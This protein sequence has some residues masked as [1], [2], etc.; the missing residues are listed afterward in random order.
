MAV[1]RA[2]PTTR[3]RTRDRQDAVVAVE[4]WTEP[5]VV[6]DDAAPPL[7]RDRPPRPDRG[8]PRREARD[9]PEEHRPKPAEVVVRDEPGPPPRARAALRRELRGQRPA[10]DRE[11][12]VAGH[13]DAADVDRVLLEHRFARQDRSPVQEHLGERRDAAEAQDDL[14]AGGGRRRP[15]RR[16]EPPVLGVQVAGL[17]PGVAQGPRRGP[18]HGRRDPCQVVEIVR[19]RA[20]ARRRGRR[21]PAVDDRDQDVARRPGLE[22][23][24]LRAACRQATASSSAPSASVQA[25]LR[26]V[27]ASVGSNGR[28][29]ASLK[30]R[31]LQPSTMRPIA[32]VAGAPRSPSSHSACDASSSKPGARH[33]ERREGERV[34]ASLVALEERRQVGRRAAPRTGRTGC[35]AGRDRDGLGAGRARPRAAPARGWPARRRTGSAPCTAAGRRAT[36]P[37]RSGTH[38]GSPHPRAR[39]ARRCG[40]SGRRS[41][42]RSIASAITPV[43][44]CPVR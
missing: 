22:R 15:E 6:D 20:L 35:P 26:A 1:G 44:T 24:S 13:E 41:R 28:R 23:T 18:G 40:S 9:A 39:R 42:S 10:A 27:M 33:P 12:V 7:Q 29:R 4:P 37:A 32:S 14:L 30:P 25:S 43:F 8:R 19:R 17:A 38:P 11:L 21:L 5:E 36:S 31:T 34:V 2:P 16:P 3:S